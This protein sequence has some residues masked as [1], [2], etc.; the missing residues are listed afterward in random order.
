MSKLSKEAELSKK[1][2]NHSIRSTVMGLLGEQYEG[3]IVIGWSGHRSEGTIKQYIRRIPAK[4]KREIS[5]YLGNNIKP[6]VAK[7]DAAKFTF[8]A[9][10]ATVSKPEE[11]TSSESNV[12][13]EESYPQPAPQLPE[14]Y[15]LQA[16][17]NAPNDEA[18]IKILEDIEKTNEGL[19][20][21]AGPQEIQ[22]VVMPN[23]Q[24]NPLV[25]NNTMNIQQNV[26]NV[27]NV[28]PLKPAMMPSM[29]FGGHSTVTINYNFNSPK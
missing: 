6:K 12:V 10:P 19:Q 27:Q 11:N 28:H 5:N 9:I 15:D 3:R 1:Y 25:P 26:Q 18:L 21:Q 23:P 29:Y 24:A 22:P 20:A 8:R 16:F 7:E 17:D 4:K 14:L 2:T 13:P